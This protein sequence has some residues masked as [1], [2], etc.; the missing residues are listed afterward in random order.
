MIFSLPTSHEDYQRDINL[1]DQL[2]ALQ[3]LDETTSSVFARLLNKVSAQVD[4]TS[5]CG[6][7][8]RSV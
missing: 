3:R 2:H 6:G 4:R 5:E 1:I 7:H 8:L